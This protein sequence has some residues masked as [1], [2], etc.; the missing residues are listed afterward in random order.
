MG[1]DMSPVL[2]KFDLR[3]TGGGH[4]K[5]FTEFCDGDTLSSHF[6]NLD[7]LKFCQF[8]GRMFCSLERSVPSNIRPISLFCIPP[9][10]IKMIPNAVPVSM[11]PFIAGRTRAD[12]GEED[13]PV[14]PKGEGFPFFP[15]GYNEISSGFSHLDN[16][17]RIGLHVSGVFIALDPPLVANFIT[18]IARNRFPLLLIWIKLIITH[19]QGLLNRLR[20][21]GEPGRCLRTVSGSI[22]YRTI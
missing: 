1:S 5:N 6:P 3:N 10:I 20:L 9:Q 15:Q 8:M 22:N 17:R 4:R 18:R 14:N 19:G 2:A 16:P 21:W 12:E 7:N 11:A 13:K